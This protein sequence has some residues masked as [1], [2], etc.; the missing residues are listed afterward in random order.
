MNDQIF[1]KKYLSGSNFEITISQ[2]GTM[3]SRRSGRQSRSD[4]VRPE[5]ISDKALRK[6]VKT[7]FPVVSVTWREVTLSDVGSVGGGVDGKLSYTQTGVDY[8]VSDFRSRNRDVAKRRR[9][10][11]RLSECHKVDEGLHNKYTI[12]YII[13]FFLCIIVESKHILRKISSIVKF[14]SNSPALSLLLEFKL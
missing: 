5:L 9:L 10:S 13:L 12:L 2:T 3:K 4:A 11:C 8:P 1:K 7:S 6:L 14:C